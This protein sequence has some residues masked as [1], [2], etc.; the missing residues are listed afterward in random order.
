MLVKVKEIT[1]NESSPAEINRFT[2]PRENS[3]IAKPPKANRFSELSSDQ[4]ATAASFGDRQRETILD[5][6]S[7]VVDLIEVEYE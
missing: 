6:K 1:P 3:M 2:V 5:S 7:T 4:R